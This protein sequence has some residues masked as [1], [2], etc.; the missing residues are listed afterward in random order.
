MSVQFGT[1]SHVT[2]PCRKTRF[3][4]F[5]KRFVVARERRDRGYAC[6]FEA[7]LSSCA[8]DFRFQIAHTTRL[9][10]QAGKR[11]KVNNGR[12][13]ANRHFRLKREVMLKSKRAAGRAA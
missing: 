9:T 2:H 13:K 11:Q 6:Y 5:A 1:A 7:K 12:T 4:P 10:N 3:A 8:F